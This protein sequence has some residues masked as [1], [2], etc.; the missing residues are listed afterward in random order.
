M[1]SWSKKYHV[2]SSMTNETGYAM[3]LGRWQPLHDGHKELFNQTLS[4]GQRIC[5]MIRDIMPDNKNPYSAEEV[6]FNIEAVYNHEIKLGL[7][8]ILIVPNITSI[9]FGRNVGYDII[10]HIPPKHVA[11]I[12]ATKIREELKNNGKL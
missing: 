5:I 11:E 10:E 9:N 2:I 7:V 4:K 8:K 1:N 6:K 3:F 12:S